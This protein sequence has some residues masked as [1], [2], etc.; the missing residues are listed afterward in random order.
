MLEPIFAVGTEAGPSH[1][2]Q[3][4]GHVA[5]LS[6][7]HQPTSIRLSTFETLLLQLDFPLDGT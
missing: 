2:R 1:L 3:Y 6:M 7:E 5:E 4:I